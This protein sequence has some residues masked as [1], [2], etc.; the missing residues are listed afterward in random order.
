MKMDTDLIFGRFRQF[1]GHLNFNDGRYLE[2]EYYYKYNRGREMRDWLDPDALDDLQIR[3][4]T[5]NKACLTDAATNDVSLL[6]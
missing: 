3:T 5:C 6:P 1:Y 2:N 4:L